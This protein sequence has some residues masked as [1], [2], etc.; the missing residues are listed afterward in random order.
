MRYLVMVQGTQADYDAM[1]GRPTAHAPSWT[2]VQ[3]KAMYLYMNAINDELAE[4]GELV[5]ARG[6]AE[7]ARTR[8]VARGEG[9]ETVITDAPYAETEP[10][11]TGYWVL[12]CASLERVTE[13]AERVT[14]C[15]GPE[16]LAEHPVVIRPLME[17]LDDVGA[18]TDPTRPGD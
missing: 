11:P 16:S 10:L 14:R 1:A 13:I 5:E 8:L 12:D 9:G 15:P 17:S 7:P 18:G 6:L 3:L 2:Q 4:S